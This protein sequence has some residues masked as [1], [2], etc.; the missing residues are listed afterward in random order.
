MRLSTLLEANNVT[1]L[2][3]K[4]LTNT[5]ICQ[6]LA[7]TKDEK[8]SLMR[9]Y[10]FDDF[11]AFDFNDKIEKCEYVGFKKYEKPFSGNFHTY[12][13]VIEN[14][15]G[16]KMVHNVSVHIGENS[17]YCEI[18]DGQPANSPKN[19]AHDLMS[20]AL[21]KLNSAD[22]ISDEE[23]QEIV[24]MISSAYEILDNAKKV[25]YD[26]HNAIENFLDDLE[27]DFD[28][29]EIVDKLEQIID[30]I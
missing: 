10:G 9:A 29:D 26:L 28:I 15:K 25:S 21:A 16:A 19:Q 20:A 18:Y 11:D 24:K 1:Q 22:S 7:N 30:E 6:L 14:N 12:K 3:F 17:I 23:T 4:K 8:S 13:M 5:D 2:N 27:G